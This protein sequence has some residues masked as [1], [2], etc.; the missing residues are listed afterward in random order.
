MKEIN[1]PYLGLSS[2][3]PGL[4]EVSRVLDAIGLAHEI[5]TV[6]WPGYANKP[7]VTFKIGYGEQEIFLKFIVREHFVKAQMTRSNQQVYEDSCVEFFVAPS[8]DGIYFN[9][10]FNAIGTILMGRGKSRH[11]D[12]LCDPAVISHIR[13]SGTLGTEPF[14]ERRGDQLWELTVAIPYDI[15]LP[16]GMTS[17]AGV[18]IRANFYKCGDK[19]SHPHYLSWN[20]IETESPDF[21]RP[22]YFGTLRFDPK[23]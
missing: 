15:F 3:Q 14:D 17:P 4:D 16:E 23:I 11:D 2:P 22:E 19:L 1:V 5:G 21:H 20:P 9:F 12:R 7:E 8:N 6:N 18:T 13:R 10:E